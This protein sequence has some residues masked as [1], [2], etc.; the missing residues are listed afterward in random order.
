M[1]ENSNMPD[2]DDLTD[3]WQQSPEV[4]MDKMARHA[5]FVWWRMRINFAIE[6]VLCLGG[7]ALFGWHLVTGDAADKVGGTALSVAMLLLCGLGLWASCFIR[8]GAW[9]Q[10]DGTAQ[11]LVDLQIRRA[12]SSVRYMVVN[13]WGCGLGLLTFIYIY[14]SLIERYG[15][16]DH[17][18]LT[19]ANYL[20]VGTILFFLLFPFFTIPFLKRKRDEIARLEALAQQLV[21]EGDRP[22]DSPEDSPEGT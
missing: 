18:E 6:V 9:G 3:I 8:A 10:A 4:D 15:A 19:V 20:M 16:I 12:R 13:N 17:P 14:W 11:S 5:R 21:D 1:T 2:W 22:E 7:M